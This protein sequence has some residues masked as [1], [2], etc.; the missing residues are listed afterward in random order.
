M[1]ADEIDMSCLDA[2]LDYAKEYYLDKGYPPEAAYRRALEVVEE[3]T[4]YSRGKRSDRGG[5]GGRDD[6]FTKRMEATYDP[7]SYGGGVAEFRDEVEGNGYRAGRGCGQPSR[8]GYDEYGRGLASRD[9]YAV[10]D[11]SLRERYSTSQDY[12]ERELQGI[13]GEIYDKWIEKGASREEARREAKKW[14]DR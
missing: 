6:R 11:P 5:R 4:G 14:F 3:E 1:Y 10:R 13:L 9:E 8:K 2:M 12:T 7:L